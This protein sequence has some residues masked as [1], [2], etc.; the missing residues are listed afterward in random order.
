M[1]QTLSPLAYRVELPTQA[2]H[3]IRSDEEALEVAHRLAASFRLEALQRDQQRRLP[4]A[5]LDQFSQSGLLAARVPKAYGGAEISYTTVARTVSIVSAADPSLG[6]L[7]LS[8][9]LSNAIIDAVGRPE[10]KDDFFAKVLLG[11]RWGNGHAEAGGSQSGVTTTRVTRQGERYVVNGQKFYS[12]GA[13]YSHLISVGCLDENG[14]SVTAVLARHA[15]GLTILDDWDGFGQ[16]TTASG[17]LLLNNVV[18]EASHLLDSERARATSTSFGIPDLVHSAIDLGIAQ[19]AVD[20][21]IAYVREHAR[22]FR[23]AGVERAVDD[24]Y[25][26]QEVGNLVTRL[27]AAEALLERGAGIFDRAVASKDPA[28]NTAAAVALAEAK[29]LTTEVSLLA[30]NKL[31]Q[32]GGASSTLPSHGY[33][34]HWRNARTHT[35]HDPVHWKFPLIGSHYLKGNGK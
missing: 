6:Q 32:L 8:I 16:R 33:D 28:A 14:K 1:T 31:F 11:Y 3:I 7:M 10:Q 9:L 29:I 15:P 26:Q 17:T 34:R 18:V 23:R 22:A 13:L 4:W 30:S 25:I 24:P 19:A 2:A 35:V 12:T 21:T 20:D 5:E 27:H